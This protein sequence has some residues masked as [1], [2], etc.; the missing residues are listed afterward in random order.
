M[1]DDKISKG[2]ILKIHRGPEVDD[3]DGDDYNEIFVEQIIIKRGENGWIIIVMYEDDTESM[4]VYNVD[5]KND[6]DKE[7]VKQILESMGLENTIKLK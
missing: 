4:F 6:G 5:D 3:G 1:E 2:K 7:A